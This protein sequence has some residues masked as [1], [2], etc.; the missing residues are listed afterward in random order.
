MVPMTYER[1]GWEDLPGSEE[2]LW[3]HTVGVTYAGKQNFPKETLDSE[4]C[5]AD[6]VANRLLALCEVELETLK[7]KNKLLTHTKEHLVC[8]TR[9]GFA[10]PLHHLKV[11]FLHNKNIWQKNARYR[12]RLGPY[13]AETV[14]HGRLQKHSGAP[15]VWLIDEKN[16]CA[17]TCYAILSLTGW[18]HQINQALSW[19]RHPSAKMFQNFKHINQWSRSSAFSPK[20]FK[21]LRKLRTVS[22]CLDAGE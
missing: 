13:A 21:A 2:A 3:Q 22:S 5:S 4:C 10:K 11:D 15:G 17:S 14:N 6:K 20:W 8:V 7:K 16:K 9:R 12:C 18:S 1:F 19:I